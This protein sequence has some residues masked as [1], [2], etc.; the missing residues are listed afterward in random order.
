M[1]VD[2]LFLNQHL[3]FVFVVV[4]AEEVMDVGVGVV[5]DVVGEGNVK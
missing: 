2:F 3:L 5:V 1:D 4:G